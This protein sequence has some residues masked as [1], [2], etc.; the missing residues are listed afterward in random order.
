ML[1]NQSN[2]EA[3]FTGYKTAFNEAFSGVQPQWDRVATLVPSTGKAEH[4]GW[5]GQFP[6]LREWVGDRVV[7]NLQAHDW[8]IS[9][10][11]FESTVAV[12]RSDI[13]DDTYGVY[14][15][16][17]SQ[18]G[19]QSAKHPDSLVFALLAS[20]FSELCYDGQYFFDSD[21]PV[22]NSTVS[23]YQS[24]SGNPWF[25][26]DTRQPIKPLIFQRRRDYQ[27]RQ[28]TRSDDEQVFMRDEYRYGVDARVNAGFGLWQLAYGS[29]ADLTASNYA[30]AYADMMA[31][32]NDEGQPLGVSPNLL[33]V[34]PS[35]R[36]A[37]L[38]IVMAERNSSGATNVNR[39]SAEVLVVPWLT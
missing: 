14:T 23:N 32:E 27:L 4:Y 37:A 17:F 12:P 35:N 18:M 16:L 7:K 13:E 36:A 29:K 10:R 33:V 26:L 24:G 9:N 8:R 5:L 22:G 38:E 21:H 31:M 1:I 15:P 28:M 19:D 3:L 6:A 2:L 25:L 30:T 39:N 20:G 11:A 34:G